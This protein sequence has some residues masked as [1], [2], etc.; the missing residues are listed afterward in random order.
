M[1]P[2]GVKGGVFVPAGEELAVRISER[3]GGEEE[4]VCAS[5]LVVVIDGKG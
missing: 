2:F 1:C 3:W 5:A 4:G